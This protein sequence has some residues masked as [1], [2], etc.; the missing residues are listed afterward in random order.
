MLFLPASSPEF[1]AIESLFGR[2]KVE[3]RDLRYRTKEDLANAIVKI[4]FSMA[5]TR[6]EGFFRRT[7]NDMM[8]YYKEQDWN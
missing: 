7:L 6:L 1:S 2:V 8:E 5:K 4:S 3:L